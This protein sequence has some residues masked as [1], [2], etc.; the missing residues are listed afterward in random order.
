[1]GLRAARFPIKWTH[2][3]GKVS[4]KTEK[5]EKLLFGK[6]RQPFP[7]LAGAEADVAATGDVALKLS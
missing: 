6:G 5:L 1:L 7:G 2:V 3:I 4:R